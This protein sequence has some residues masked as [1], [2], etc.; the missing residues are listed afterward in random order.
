MDINYYEDIIHP[1]SSY[2]PGWVD[3]R[4]DWWDRKDRHY[5]KVTVLYS[6]GSTVCIDIIKSILNNEAS[7]GHPFIVR[8]ISHLS[9]IVRYHRALAVNK[10]ESQDSK[11][12]GSNPSRSLYKERYDVAKKQLER[13]GKAL[14]EGAAERA[15]NAETAFDFHTR[16]E[17][18]PL[19]HTWL[20]LQKEEVKS[21]PDPKKIEAIKEFFNQGLEKVE[22]IKKTLK[23]NPAGELMSEFLSSE[24]GCKF[25]K[26][27][28]R[29]YRSIRNIFADWLFGHKQ[30]SSTAKTYRS[31]AKKNKSKENALTHFL[32]PET[33]NKYNILESSNPTLIVVFEQSNKPDSQIVE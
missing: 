11:R 16:F 30:L 17:D 33:N 13:I 2:V 24:D 18:T 19:R 3:I 29:D 26:N 14:A 27:P 10:K 20:F 21:M 28:G 6:D 31:R 32:F 8:A 12:R 9:G 25:L 22:G 15:L 5:P 7:I 4:I 23:S 1:V